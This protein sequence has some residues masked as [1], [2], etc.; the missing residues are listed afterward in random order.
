MAAVN[1]K[2]SV[3]RSPLPR[4]KARQPALT[5]IQ[6]APAKYLDYLKGKSVV[7]VGP[8]AYLKDKGLGPWIDSHDVVVKMNWGETLP[9]EDYGSRTD[10]LYK[11]L[12]KLGHADE[13]LIQEYL[14]AGIQWVVAVDNPQHTPHMEYLTR[15]I[16]TRINWFVENTTR[17]LMTR[18]LGT[19]ALLGSITVRHLLDRP[20]KSL[21]ITGC[22]FY[23]TGYAPEYGG[24]NYRWYMKRREGT[25]GPT[26][27]GPKQLRWLVEETKK[28]KRLHLD[29]HME[30]IVNTPPEDPKLM[31]GVLVIIPARYKSTRFPGKPLAEISGKPMI[32][33]VCDRVAMATTRLVVATD[34]QRIA[35]AVKAAGYKAVMTKDAMTGTDRIAQVAKTMPANIYVNVQGD[36]PLVDPEAIKQ[37]VKLKRKY[38]REVINAVTRLK[39]GEAENRDVVKAALKKG[40]RLA[41]ASR[42]AIPAGH[43]AHQAQWKQLGLYAFTR[44]EL[45][46]YSAATRRTELEEAEDVEI[47]RFLDLGIPV[48]MC[49]VSGSAQAVD[50]PSHIPVIEQML[51]VTR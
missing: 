42:A 10:V 26:H 22:D 43:D 18:Q 29:E 3:G 6:A 41:Y 37:L 2:P 16:G 17:Q 8:A 14:D 21:D 19:S 31:E 1:G 20:I 35:D 34:D 4:F 30:T 50:L 51:G 12:L 48:H 7:L 38:P 24:K 36:E 28:D 15:V 47:L 49:E 9:A 11:R 23:A 32:V 25:I 27:D 45:I 5:P 39:E 44:A 13:I 40:N 33:R 46:A